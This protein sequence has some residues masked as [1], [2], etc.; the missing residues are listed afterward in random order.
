MKVAIASVSTVMM[1]QFWVKVYGRLLC[2]PVSRRFKEA[3]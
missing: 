1:S 3:S 2:L